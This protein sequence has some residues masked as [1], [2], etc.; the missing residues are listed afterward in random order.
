MWRPSRARS[1]RRLSGA[2][3]FGKSYSALLLA[4]GITN[5][6]NKIAVIDAYEIFVEESPTIFGELF[7]LLLRNQKEFISNEKEFISE[8]RLKTISSFNA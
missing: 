8:Y 4:Y 3:G 6:W 5:N 7:K 2:S 1:P